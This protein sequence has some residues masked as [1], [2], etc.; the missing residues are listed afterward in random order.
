MAAVERESPRLGPEG[1][2]SDP[3]DTGRAALQ[4]ILTCAR[5]A[6]MGT[7]SWWR[8]WRQ[9]AARWRRRNGLAAPHAGWPGLVH[10]AWGWYDALSS[11]LEAVFVIAS[12]L[13]L[14]A[15]SVYLVGA[16]SLV[17]AARQAG[18]APS[19]ASPAGVASAT[20]EPTIPPPTTDRKS[21]V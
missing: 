12:I 9:R 11:P 20:P 16:S 1:V 7:V 21:V 6:M 15:T 14:L 2:V 19:D 18:P 17:A 5:P 13:F 10:Q 3:V 8:G 4:P